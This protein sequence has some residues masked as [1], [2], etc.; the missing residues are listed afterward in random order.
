[1]IPILLSGIGMKN[2]IKELVWEMNSP[3]RTRL[4]IY[5]DASYVW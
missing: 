2:P 1:M 4:G 3:N 5:D